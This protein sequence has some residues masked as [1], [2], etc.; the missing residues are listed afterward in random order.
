MVPDGGYC[1]LGSG[2]GIVFPRIGWRTAGP[3]YF[4][5]AYEL[6]KQDAN[7]I[8]RLAILQQLRGEARYYFLAGQILTPFVGASAGIVG[9]GNEWSIDTLGPEGAATLGVEA[10][11]ARD[12][13]IGLALNY[14]VMYFH[15][16]IDS[17][18]TPRD[19]SVAQLWGL[20]LQLEV[21]EP[22]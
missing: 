4:C 19:G 5:G 13:V 18:D 22:F 8:Y 12:T 15:P 3:W 20:D 7:T 14:R 11:V 6:S 21:R 17:S 2:G 1:I 10:Q 16:F 9:Y